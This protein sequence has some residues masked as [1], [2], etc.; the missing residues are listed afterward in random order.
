MDRYGH[1]ERLGPEPA[2][3][4]RQP[5]EGAHR[6]WSVAFSPDGRTLASGSFGKS[7][8][9]WNVPPA[10]PLTHAVRSGPFLLDDAG[11]GRGQMRVHTA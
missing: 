1:P 4:A 8:R 2:Q 5:A 11:R 9:P 10:L 3:V 7:V 6:L